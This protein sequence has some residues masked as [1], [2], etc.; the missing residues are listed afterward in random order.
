MPFHMSDYFR[1]D[2][3]LLTVGE[4]AELIGMSPGTV[5]EK[6]RKKQLPAIRKRGRGMPYL[7]HHSDLVDFMRP[8]VVTPSEYIKVD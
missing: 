4:A 8:E 5:R 1:N 3:P 6:I 2:D 7:I